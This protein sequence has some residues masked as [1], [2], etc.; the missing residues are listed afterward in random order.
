[1]KT[2]KQLVYEFIVEY[3]NE[4]KNIEDECP[5]IETTFLSEKLNMQRSNVSSVLNQLVKEGKIIKSQGRPVLYS[6]ANE[7]EV[8]LDDQEF[9]KMIGYDQSLKDTIKIVKVALN[10]P[11]QIPMILLIG[12]K[13]V[14][15]ETL[16]KNTHFYACSKGIL[17]K[18]APYTVIDSS[19]YNEEQLRN[20]LLSETNVFDKTNNGLLLIKNASNISKLRFTEI[21]KKIESNEY[22]FILMIHVNELSKESFFKNYINYIASIPTLNERSYSERYELIVKFVK[23][24]AAKINKRIG[25]NYG[26]MQ[27]LLLFPTENNIDGLK[28]NLQFGIANAFARLKRNATI[29]LELSDFNDEVRKGLLYIKEANSDIKDVIGNNSDFVF[30]KDTTYRTGSNNEKLDIYHRLDKKKQMI[31]KSIN[32]LE[33]DNFIFGNIEIELNDYL[34]TL[35]K[36]ID[37]AK[38]RS[39]VSPKLYNLVK[40][41]ISNAGKKFNQVYPNEIFFGICMHL[42]N[43]IV[44]TNHKQRIS[45]NK[46]MEIIEKYDEEYFFSK[47]F[48][49]LIESEFNVRF[50]SDETVFI[51]L[52][53]TLPFSKT[54]Q[55]EVVTLV[56]MHGE[57]SAS[58]I[59]EVAKKLMP[60][61][62]IYSFDLPLEMDIETAYEKLKQKLIEINQGKG[63]IVIYDMG[64]IQIMIDSIREET[65]LNIRYLEIP[66]S[67]LALSSCKYSE[68]GHDVDEVYNHLMDEYN[69]NLYSGTIRKN[70]IIIA[71]SSIKENMGYKIKEKILTYKDSNNYMIYDFNIDEKNALVSKINEIN[72]R[73]KI[74]G[75]IGTYNPDLFNLKFVDYYHLKETDTIQEEFDDL[76]NE[77][78]LFEYLDHQ[79]NELSRADLEITLIPFISKIENTLQIK[80]KEDERIGLLI[81]MTSLIDRL[82]KKQGPVVYF[83]VAEII[84]RYPGQVEYIK[85]SLLPI[86]RHFDISI[87][88]GDAATITRIILKC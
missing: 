72:N 16:C 23:E 71:L 37:D 49:K 30:D 56:A 50:S 80:L 42:N 38:L 21:M 3:S 75:I 48:I 77:F 6:L 10:Y 84:D 68:E 55:N 62:N 25:I 73:G 1:M 33:A 47:K 76:E 63:I 79:F 81:H 24:E 67:L 57:S 46:I 51:T 54:I 65:N 86:E 20:E 44:T 27:S 18:N 26:L 17:K 14:G 60:V 69:D 58:S 36:N 28:K 12:E 61:K 22:H 41:F 87:S 8:L 53:L 2:K 88:D 9:S 66:I 5:K 70:N 82:M 39:I 7:Q 31:N 29:N 59:V 74:V 45:N 15:I 40:D 11:T 85:Q 4:F 32:S 35:I 19:L 78:D 13:G 34:Q 83:N 64:S 43:I 52:F